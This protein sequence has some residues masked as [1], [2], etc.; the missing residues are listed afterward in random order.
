MKLKDAEILLRYPAPTG[1]GWLILD[2]GSR[3]VVSYNFPG[4]GK[5]RVSLYWNTLDIC[6]WVSSLGGNYLYGYGSIQVSDAT[7]DLLTRGIMP[8]QDE[9]NAAGALARYSRS[10]RAEKNEDTDSR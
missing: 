5:L 1:A 10:L 4:S 7:V 3:I 2:H 6:S 8:E 9:L